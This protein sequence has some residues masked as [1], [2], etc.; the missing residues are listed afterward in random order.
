MIQ[1]ATGAL[2]LPL[3]WGSCVGEVAS[4]DPVPKN[5]HS[6]V[7]SVFRS[8]MGCHIKQKIASISQH[9]W[10]WGWLSMLDGIWYL[11]RGES[12]WSVRRK[13]RLRVGI[14]SHATRPRTGR[15]WW[16]IWERDFHWNCLSDFFQSSADACAYDSD[17]RNPILVMEQFCVAS[18]RQH[19][20][21]LQWH[22]NFPWQPKQLLCSV[23]GL[24]FTT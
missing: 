14:H 12:C 21:V 4:N 10:C 7:S 15:C 13:R 22:D 9:A 3:G 6:R 2:G 17:S 24:V 11:L 5:H 18:C 8:S 16:R 23:R 20:F 1:D 19:W